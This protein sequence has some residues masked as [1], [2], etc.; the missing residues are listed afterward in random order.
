MYAIIK[1]P[2]RTHVMT[3][4][5]L[6]HIKPN[7]VVGPYSIYSAF[8]P[9][10]LG[11]KG[12][13]LNE[14][15]NLLDVNDDILESFKEYLKVDKDLTNTKELITY[16]GIFIKDTYKSSFKE[17]FINIMENNSMNLMLF[18]DKEVV[19]Y[20]NNTVSKITNG[21]IDSLLD[22]NDVKDDTTCI[23]VNAIY[24]IG[25]WK[26]KFKKS[27]TRDTTFNSLNN[28]TQVKMMNNKNI[29]LKYYEDF[30]C[31]FVSIPYTDNEFA[32][33]IVL[34][35]SEFK[36][37]NTSTFTNCINNAGYKNVN[38]YIPKFEQRTKLSLV[39]TLQKEGM[40][41]MFDLSASN[42]SNMCEEPLCISDIIHECVIKLDEI[43]TEAAAVTAIKLT[44]KCKIHRNES[45]T[46]KAD[47][48]F[49][50]FIYHVETN[51]IL[52]TG[53]FDG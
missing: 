8:H 35:I 42:F 11:A 20:I 23:L 15:Y 40:S 14:I 17:E 5:I 24:F 19:P 52:F 43:K 29:R 38:L 6:N 44:N 13:T 16:N 26:T 30:D 39:E 32:L 22:D 9:L 53:I 34:P 2:H 48:T 12:D 50:Y 36:K 41:N 10:L 7:Q 4:I 18:K 21:L 33:G 3:D 51:T 28:E 37:V 45:I 25:E 27:N 31:K 47:H 46:F 49:T 1:K